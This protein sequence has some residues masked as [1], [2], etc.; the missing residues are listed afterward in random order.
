M[1]TL[2]LVVEH[3]ARLLLADRTLWLVSGLFLLLVSYGLFNGM[4]QAAVKENALGKVL[5]AE[6][7]GEA[8][9]RAL[10]VRILNNGAMPDPFGNP[11]D[12]SAMGG[13]YGS[14]YAYM[15]ISPL[16]S[17]AFGQ[18][19]VRPDYYKVTNRSKI[20]FIYDTEIENPWNLLS[21][22]FDLSFVI[23]YLFPLLIFA[24]SYNFLSAE[25]E[26][27]T[28]KMLLSQSLGLPT[29]VAGKIAVR[30][31]ALLLWAAVVPLVA[32]AI[33]RP[34]ARSLEHVWPLASWAAFVVAYGGIWF[35]L[36]VAVNAFGRSSATNALMLVGSWIVCVLVVP[37]LL[38]VAVAIVR[39]AP[40]RTELATRTRLVTS[41]A[42]NRNAEL[43][44]A[45]YQYVNDAE[46]LRPKDG[47]IV[48]AGRMRGIYLMEKDVDRE[49]EGLLD[50]F[51]VQLAGQQRLVT[52]YGALSPAIVT[53]E[54]LTALAGTGIRRHLHFQKQIDAFHRRW[55]D[56]FDPKILNGVAITEEDFDRMPRFTWTEED[57]AVVQGGVVT[58]LLQLLLPA[59]GLL[60]IGLW[61]LRRYAVV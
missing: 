51:N 26:H 28:L 45:D 49:L 58:G 54:G 20:S 19:D 30:A 38:N 37:V 61:R 17:L 36:A 53:Y 4:E 22:H 14:R 33:M 59:A 39:P 6:A 23:V 43:L 41:D 3:E 9:R 2:K 11:T 21:G 25:R 50:A 1:R 40:S 5:E 8:S 27:G 13:G 12:P 29:L 34:E 24:L 47:K 60:A 15:P 56:F 55:R 48:V 18:S 32:L 10:L 46:L 52:R 35:A 16:A 44:A 7:R 31:I 42:L 57:P